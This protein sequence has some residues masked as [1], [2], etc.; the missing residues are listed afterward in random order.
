MARDLSRRGDRRGRELADLDIR[1][2]G[3]EQRAAEAAAVI[4]AAGI[5]VRGPYPRRDE[6]GRVSY[7]ARL[8]AGETLAPPAAGELPARP[9]IAGRT[10]TEG[11]APR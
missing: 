2:V 7:Y 8:P 4:R 6:P 3:T 11:E 5:H 9:A 1:I 10:T